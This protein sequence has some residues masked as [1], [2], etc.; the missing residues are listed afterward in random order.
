MIYFVIT[1]A[2]WLRTGVLMMTS[3]YQNVRLDPRSVA[4][5]GGPG[6]RHYQVGPTESDT[7]VVKTRRPV[8]FFCL[9]R[10]RPRP[11]TDSRHRPRRYTRAGHRRP[12]ESRRLS[13]S[14]SSPR[15][16][17]SASSTTGCLGRR[18]DGT[19]D[20]DLLSSRAR[21]NM[22]RAVPRTMNGEGMLRV[23]RGWQWFC[24]KG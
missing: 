22:R 16:R 4:Q 19:D 11:A 23:L 13:Q 7:P 18:T 20:S 17:Q 15:L 2:S 1:C 6:L 14:A 24:D 10:C 9:S 5:C 3:P 21:R 8:P 12:P